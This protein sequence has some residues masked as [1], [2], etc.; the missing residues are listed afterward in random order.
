MTYT[1]QTYIA[2]EPPTVWPDIHPPLFDW[3]FQ[4]DEF[5]DWCQGEGTWQLHCVGGP[6]S[7]KTTLSALAVRRLREHCQQTSR[8]AVASL[9]IRSDV[10]SNEADLV[11]DMLNS[12]WCQL[13]KN[14]D[15]SCKAYQQY[16][17]ACQKGSRAALRI[18]AIRKALEVRLRDLDG[19]FVIL[20]DLDRCSPALDVLLRDQ[21]AILQRHH[22]KIMT[23]SRYPLWDVGELDVESVVP[24]KMFCDGPRCPDLSTDS[25]LS[26]FWTCAHCWDYPSG[27]EEY[28]VLCYS[29]IK[30]DPQCVYC[31]NT[32]KF[33]EPYDHRNVEIDNIPH[34]SMIS[35]VKWDLERE[36]GDLGFQIPIEARQRPSSKLGIALRQNSGEGAEELQK[37][38]VERASGNV[39]MAKLRLE[40]TYASTSLEEVKVTRDRLPHHIVATFD[41]GVSRIEEQPR[42]QRELG[43]RIIAASCQASQG[44]PLKTLEQWLGQPFRSPEDLYQVTGGL[45]KIDRTTE[46]RVEAYHDTFGV[47][48]RENYNE[49]IF[50]ARSALRI[51][52]IPRSASVEVFR[53]ADATPANEEFLD[54]FASPQDKEAQRSAVTT[55]LDE[56]SSIS[57]GLEDRCSLARLAKVERERSSCC[58]YIWRSVDLH[59]EADNESS[60]LVQGSIKPEFET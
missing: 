33:L 41:A 46:R 39:G 35:F 36:H 52:R 8:R 7:G 45:V 44:V 24:E 6:G 43:L 42:A 26:L 3:F 13:G 16:K 29:C 10:R 23:T 38:I 30:D 28:F 31:G 18:K 25:P 55:L 51:K 22:L 20:D 11:E 58:G 34:S 9:F 50:R 5:L 17:E 37:T 15:T 19:S 57:I 14:L 49:S 48:V 2:E 53:V 27:A 12:I 54:L 4:S 60:I 59:K 40:M 1:F 47:Y 56:L 32:S 21:L